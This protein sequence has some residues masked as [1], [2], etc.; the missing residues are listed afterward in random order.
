MGSTALPVLFPPNGPYFDGGVLMN[1]PITPAILLNEPDILYVVIPT[2]KALGRTDNI[3]EIGQTVLA[4]WT[5]MSLIA[6]LDRLELRNR[7]RKDRREEGEPDERLPICVIR[8]PEDLTVTFG[9]NLL[10]FGLNVPEIVGA[11]K[12]AADEKLNR[13]DP[14]DPEEAT[15]YDVQ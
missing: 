15:W 4:T 11:G 12:A 10:S 14:T 5:V 8:P 3:I 6:Q 2:A 9:V 13:F 7:M 1:Q